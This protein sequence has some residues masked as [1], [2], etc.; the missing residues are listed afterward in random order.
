MIYS[1]SLVLVNEQVSVQ[2]ASHMAS[3]LIA[4]CVI[5]FQGSIGAGKTTLIRAMLEAIGVKDRIQSP[6]YSIVARYESSI[7]EIYH[8]DLYRIVDEE[9]LEEIG[10]RDCF[11]QNALCFIE[12]PEN[13]P[14]FYSSMDVLCDLGF[15][16]EGRQLNV[17]ALT[18]AGNRLL[19]SLKIIP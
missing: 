19:T 16:H 4:P 12:W 10:F 18:D 7:G 15:I 13:A 2:F 17:S 5:G 8:F 9:E 6:T 3:C 1:S 11:H 14:Y